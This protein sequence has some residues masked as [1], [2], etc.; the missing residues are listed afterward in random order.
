MT[1]IVQINTDLCV[2]ASFL[3]CALSYNSVKLIILCRLFPHNPVRD[4][5]IVEIDGIITRTP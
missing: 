3:T 1:Q 4:V 5:I 2:V